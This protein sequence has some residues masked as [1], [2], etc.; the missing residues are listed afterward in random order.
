VARARNIK[1]AIFKN[2]L[3]GEADPILTVIF[4]GLWCLADREGRLEDRPKRIKAEI[5]PYRECPGFNG[6]LTELASLGFIRRY[7]VGGAAYIQVVN[8]LKHQAPH[9][10]ERPSEIPEPPEESDSCP[11]TV[12]APL[13]NGT[14]SVKE[15]LIP[16]SLI[17]DSL[18]KK[19][20]RKKRPPFVKPTV[21]QVSEYCRERGN[22]INAE[23]FVDHYTANGW[24]VGKT[25][26]QDWQASVRTW[27]QRQHEKSNGTSGKPVF[28]QPHERRARELAEAIARAEGAESLAADEGDLRGQILEG[29]WSRAE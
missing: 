14:T 1:P 25:K 17:P 16:D 22:N 11:L 6:Y 10:T 12:K 20:G 18:P 2:E 21:E 5:L 28:E 9:K 27:E 26:M 13:S 3:L 7:E 24:M 8:F 19:K 29:V 23:Q 4:I 15:S